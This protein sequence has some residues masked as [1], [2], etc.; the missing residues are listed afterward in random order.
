MKRCEGE[1]PR[2]LTAGY[3]PLDLIVKDLRNKDFWQSVGGTCGNVSVFAS[4]LGVDVTLLTRVGDDQRGQ[5]LVSGISKAGV[6]VE[7]V[8]K[9]TGL[10]TPAIVEVIHGTPEGTHQ[11]TH[12]CPAC[13]IRLPKQAVVSKRKADSIAK[14]IDQF[15]GFFFDRATLATLTLAEAAREAD[16]FIFFEPQSIPTTAIAKLAA[17]MSDIVKLSRP[18]SRRGKQWDLNPKASTRL[19]IETLGASGTRFRAGSQHGWDRWVE[20]PAIPPAFI[21]DTAGAGDWMTAG[22]LS[23]LLTERDFSTIEPIRTAIKFAQRLSSISIA[24]EGPQGALTAL[25]ASKIERTANDTGPISH[26]GCI[27]AHSSERVLRAETTAH[28]CEVCLTEQSR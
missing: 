22:L 26:L 21:K 25:G 15:D 23:S 1:R 17:E 19:A 11:F 28:C 13:G 8:E 4:A 24:F 2:L 5:Q 7:N 12:V 10:C 9:V 14:N 3:V 16:L 20:M 18:A 27:D 6:N